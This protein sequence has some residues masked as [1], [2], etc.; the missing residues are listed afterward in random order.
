M[1][2]FPDLAGVWS[3]VSARPWGQCVV[4]VEAFDFVSELRRSVSLCN[5]LRLHR[6]C[7]IELLLAVLSRSWSFITLESVD[8]F[9]PFFR[10]KGSCP[11][12]GERAIVAFSD[13]AWFVL[14]WSKRS[15]NRFLDEPTDCGAKDGDTIGSATARW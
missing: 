15:S 5:L 13:E 12:H 2:R 11:S 1:F 9:W 6:E 14:A 3:E 8:D 4:L 7:L 10:F